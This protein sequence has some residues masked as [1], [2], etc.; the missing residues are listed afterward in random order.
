[1]KLYLVIPVALVALL[2][3]A[4][5]VAALVRGW[6]LPLSREQVRRPRLFG[7]GQLA[8]A[9]GLCGQ[10]VFFMADDI[11]IRQFGTLSGSA[12]LLVGV[13]VMGLS[14]RRSANA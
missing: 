4:S 5:G 8:V 10:M 14:R 9:L 13:L 7:W 12:L 6:V 2:I 11:D 1:M 3:G